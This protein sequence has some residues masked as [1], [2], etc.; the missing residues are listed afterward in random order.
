M[1]ARAALSGDGSAAQRSVSDTEASMQD[2]STLYVGLDVHKDSIMVAYSIDMGDV[3][4]LG[5]RR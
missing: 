5:K 1:A 3:E 2:D 4:L